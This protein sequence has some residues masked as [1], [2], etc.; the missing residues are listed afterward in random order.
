MKRI[1]IFGGT[2]DPP[3]YGHLVMAEQV[4]QHLS[5][6]E[7]WFIPSYQPPH[8]A[9]AKTTGEDRI[10]LT[11]AAIADHPD[12]YLNTIEVERRGKSY[13]MDT[14][15]ELKEIH[16]H[17]DFYFIIGGDMVEF[18]PNWHQIDQLIEQIT[19]VG[20]KRPGFSV[21]TPY[22][23][24]EVEMPL[25]DISSTMIRDRIQK[26]QSIRYLTPPAVIKQI[27]NAKLYL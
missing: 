21:D 11:K 17:D 20:V 16:P 12:F 18:L 7:V 19:F 6:D 22:P 9:N 13:T 24:K 14:I 5:L 8:K 27:D 2:F 15:R 23:V 4:Y 10:E 25:I 26:R 3:H 1:G